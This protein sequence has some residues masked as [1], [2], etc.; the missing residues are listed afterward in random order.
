[1]LKKEHPIDHTELSQLFVYYNAREIEGT[2]SYDSGATMRDGLKGIK[3][4]GSCRYDLWPYLT[5]E[6]SKKPSPDSYEDGLRRRISKYRSLVGPYQM[7]NVLANGKPVVIGVSIYGGFMRLDK[8]NPIVPM[9]D[10]YEMSIGGHAMCV[11]GYDLPKKMFLMRNSYGAD[12]GNEG[13]CW[14]TFDYIAR[15]AFDTWTFDILLSPTP[16]DDTSVPSPMKR[17]WMLI[18]SPSFSSARILSDYAAVS[19]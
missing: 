3:N 19:I 2:T 5:S 14:M 12:W 18:S 1:M 9:P 11:V 17:S 16:T 8:K 13:Y 6:F 7:V 10:P 4:Q 15:E